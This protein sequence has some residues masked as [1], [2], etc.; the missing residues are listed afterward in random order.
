MQEFNIKYLDHF[1]GIVKKYMHMRGPYSQKE[2][3]ELVD[4]G[5]STMSRFINKKT[6]DLNS[7]LIAAIVAK[8]NIPLNEV[9]DFVDESY[10]EQ[11]KRLVQFK[12]NDGAP[13]VQGEI[14]GE[15]NEEEDQKITASSPGVSSV[16]HSP[17][18]APN[19]STN[20]PAKASGAQESL[21]E[22]LKGLS[23]RQRK[24]LEEFVNLGIDERDLIV[25]V[26]DKMFV[27]FKDRA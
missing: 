21:K 1:L 27:Y 26:A 3:A 13:P 4:V 6:T 22:K 16:T 15:K 11:F 18:P 25:D 19:T 9:I 20:P 12:R 5:V 24:F 7:Q 10:E 8:L 2:L 14:S 17:A 23:L